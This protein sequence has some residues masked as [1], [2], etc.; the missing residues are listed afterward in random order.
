MVEE[1]EED[2][3]EVVVENKGD[4]SRKQGD[5]PKAS[6]TKEE[7][8]GK[9]GEKD[10]RWEL[11]KAAECNGMAKSN[12][13]TGLLRKCRTCMLETMSMMCADKCMAE[14]KSLQQYEAHHYPPDNHHMSHWAFSAQG[15]RDVGRFGDAV[16]HE[17]ETDCYQCRDNAVKHMMGNKEVS[18]SPGN[19]DV[20]W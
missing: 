1:E 16:V 11:K 9:R 3:D 5:R 17:E 14:K 2:E 7:R 12:A 13:R 19:E 15:Y 8:G 18:G 10:N 4:G 20:R 6:R